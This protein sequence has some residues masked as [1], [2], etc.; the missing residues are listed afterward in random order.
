MATSRVQ[1]P[2][3]P[4]SSPRRR[5]GCRSLGARLLLYNRSIFCVFCAQTAAVQPRIGSGGP[6]EAPR[7]GAPRLAS[8]SGFAV[9]RRR[10]GTEE[11]RREVKRRARGERRAVSAP[12]RREGAR[13]GGVRAP[14]S[15]RSQSLE[16]VLRGPWCSEQPRCG[17]R[18]AALHTWLA[19]T[20]L[21]RGG[22]QPK[23]PKSRRRLNGDEA[24]S[25]TWEVCDFVCS[26]ARLLR[27][28]ESVSRRRIGGGAELLLSVCERRCRCGWYLLWLYRRGTTVQ[29]RVGESV[30]TKKEKK[31]KKVLA[32]V[33]ERDNRNRQMEK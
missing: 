25:L 30:A 1:P 27:F 33:V 8:N 2:L 24:A 13:H 19:Y 31:R 3:R 9:R 10:R 23:V 17:S 28:N 29:V 21:I 12:S 32:S 22:P 15:E 6:P 14:R 16:P 26:R 20:S 7:S 11:K 5:P 4:N 18:S